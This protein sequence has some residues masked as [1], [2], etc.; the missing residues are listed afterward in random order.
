MYVGRETDL[1][2]IFSTTSAMEERGAAQLLGVVEE[3]VEHLFRSV[4][5]RLQRND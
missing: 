5:R 3:Q 4:Y 2:H 1:V